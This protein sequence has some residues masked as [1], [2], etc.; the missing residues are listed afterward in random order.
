[1]SCDEIVC[2]E[3]IVDIQATYSVIDLKLSKLIVK[4]LE[5]MRKGFTPIL[6]ILLLLHSLKFVPFTDEKKG[7]EI[8]YKL[9]KCM[10]NQLYL[11]PSKW[12]IAYMM[13]KMLKLQKL[14]L[15]EYI[16]NGSLIM[17][18]DNE[19]RWDMEVSFMVNGAQVEFYNS[20]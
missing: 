3:N 20:I 12:T 8:L 15:W 7:G 5:E 1:M 13:K 16:I 11:T 6:E 17:R 19:I 9:I 14:I 4:I 2:I 18:D 10:S